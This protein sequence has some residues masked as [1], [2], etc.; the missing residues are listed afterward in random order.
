MSEEWLV[1]ILGLNVGEVTEQEKLSKTRADLWKDLRN[2]AEL[3]T[4]VNMDAKTSAKDLA[5]CFFQVFMI[6]SCLFVAVYDCS[7]N[8]I[9][10]LMEISLLF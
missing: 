3:C 5:V 1:L 9:M 8:K 10:M 7:V 6:F 4:N 2:V